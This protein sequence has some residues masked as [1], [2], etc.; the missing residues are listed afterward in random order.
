MCRLIGVES[1]K[2]AI[3]RTRLELS[4][5]LTVTRSMFRTG[6]VMMQYRAYLMENGHVWAAVDLA[7]ADDDDAKRQAENLRNGRVVELWQNDRRVALLRS[8][9]IRARSP[10]AGG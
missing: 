9:R 8:P 5:V 6:N 4:P 7:C 3:F 2:T 10:G 1:I